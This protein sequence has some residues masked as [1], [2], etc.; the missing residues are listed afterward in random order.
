MYLIYFKFIESFNFEFQTLTLAKWKTNE[1]IF[2][3]EM[4]I[5]SYFEFELEISPLN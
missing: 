3:P 5:L 1:K 4:L 2:P